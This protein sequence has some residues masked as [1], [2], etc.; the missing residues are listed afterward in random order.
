MNL[1]SRVFLGYLALV[2]LAIGFLFKSVMD[3]LRPATRQAME[4]AMVDT[5]N[6]LAEMLPPFFAKSPA[7]FSTFSVQ[8]D[9]F[10]AR[11]LNARI[12]GYTKK[13]SAYRVYITNNHGI[14]LYDSSGQDVGQDYSHWNDV[15]LTLRGKYGARSTRI[16]ERDATSSILYVAAPILQGKEIIG[17]V[18]VAKPALSIQP[19][20][21][22]SRHNVLQ[23]AIL[24]GIAALVLGGILSYWLT[25]SIRRLARY[26][27][28]VKTGKKIS[29]PKLHEPELALLANSMESMRHE[30]EGK[31][32]VEH[33]LHT[34]MHEIKSPLSGIHG[35]AELL[36]EDMP[37]EERNKFIGNIS[38]ETTRMQHIIERLLSLAA[39]ESKSH[40]SETAAINMEGLVKKVLEQ[41]SLVIE[42]KSLDVQTVIANSNDLHGDDFLIE[43]AISNLLD[44]AIDFTSMNGYIVISGEREEKTY[45]LSINDNGA[46]IPAYAL[47]KIFNRFYSLPRPDSGRK[48]SGIGLSFV[49]EV[50]TLHHGQV[51]VTSDWHGTVIKLFFPLI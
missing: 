1:F 28:D 11:D 43:Q 22:L 48:S 50:M 34:L 4:E 7:R 2:L 26:A 20:I 19:F 27:D 32:Y 31:A 44:N 24:L 45:A 40:L 16:S 3:E 12:W 33:Y 39:V 15:Y 49:R 30:L 13:S 42:Q 47:D 6:L 8:V 51:T 36:Q 38:R 17:V 29:P 25:Q 10:L 35:A 41:K 18:T 37:I 21:E 5:A 9:A 14:V 46:G 23:A